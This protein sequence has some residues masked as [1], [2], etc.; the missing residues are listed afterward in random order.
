MSEPAQPVGTLI[1]SNVLID[2][3]TA[4]PV[5]SSWS[6]QAADHAAASGPMVINPIIYA[7]VS[8]QFDRIE[9]VEALLT[10][11]E[12]IRAAIPWNAA[13]LAGQC[14]VQYRRR[15][16][17]KHSPLPDFFI[18][19]HAAVSGLRLL[20]RDAK[21]YRTYVPTVELICPP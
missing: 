21:R 20:T 14:V 7:D 18:G 5:W 8:V 11:A 12:F 15:G 9:D 6:A 16:G 1:D 13:F 3:L 17:V 19:A 4:D 10:P 2:V